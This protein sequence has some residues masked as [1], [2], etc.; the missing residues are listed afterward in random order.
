MILCVI[1]TPNFERFA[2]FHV[3]QIIFVVVLNFQILQG[4]VA[5]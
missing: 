1:H 3:K 5:A 4:S 2:K